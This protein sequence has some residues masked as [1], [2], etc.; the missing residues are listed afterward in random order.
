MT[1]LLLTG[2]LSLF[3][4]H[5]C[6]ATTAE[7]PL[8]RAWFKPTL[9][10]DHAAVCA[11]LLQASQAAFTRPDPVLEA[12][13]PRGLSEVQPREF[14]Q[15]Q[16]DGTQ[17]HFGIYTHPGCGG[18][19]EQ[20]Q[21]AA[22]LQPL[23]YHPAVT[24]DQLARSPERSSSM[25]RL[26]VDTQ[27]RVLAL[28]DD[29]E[30]SAAARN[31]FLHR[32]DEG[33]NWTRVCRIALAPQ[34]EGS[35]E[36]PRLK[37]VRL[38]MNQ[39][40]GAMGGLARGYGNC[41]SLD[42]GT[43]RAHRLPDN[44]N[45]MLHRPWALY[46]GE[47]HY[48]DPQQDFQADNHA[49]DKW[50]LTG[51]SE[52]QAAH[53][54]RQA[55]GQVQPVLAHFYSQAF[56]WSQAQSE[57]V[58]QAAL[59]AAVGN[60]L[61]FPSYGY[62]PFPD[63]ERALRQAILQSRPIKEI[64]QIDGTLSNISIAIEHPQ[65]L[66]FLLEQGSDPETRNPFGKTPLMYAAQYNQL[67]SA[68]LLLEAGADVNAMTIWP[69]DT[70]AYTL[71]TSKM[72]ALH[73][74]VRYASPELIELLLRHG[75]ATF[76][77]SVSKAYQEP[78]TGIALDWLKRHTA[79]TAREPN[80]HIAQTRIEELEQK[81]HAPS[82]EQLQ[83]HAS[84]LNLQAEKHYAEGQLT[85]AYRALLLAREASP[86]DARVLGNLSLIAFKLGN[87]GPALEAGQQV[88][89]SS[90]D[91]KQLANA[92]F[93]QGLVCEATG[94]HSYN[95]HSYCGSGSIYAYYHAASLDN[96]PAR[97]N[98]LLEQLHSPQQLR[99]QLTFAEEEVDILVKQDYRPAAKGPSIRQTLYV[100]YP[101]AI[102]LTPGDV[103]WQS[104]ERRVQPREADTLDLDQ[105]R[106]S[107][108]E[109]PE[110]LAGAPLQIGR[111]TCQPQQQ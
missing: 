79:S 70:C 74:A 93:N 64:R 75:A 8:D 27:Q 88:I 17:Q 25:P 59:E 111:D 31:L 90:Q 23:A 22:S 66:Q 107:V 10:E 43:R 14:S 44:L 4:A 41:G 97:Q 62:E 6:L 21:I 105:W 33:L 18:G 20:Y 63:E 104:K 91:A 9:Q 45:L 38:A 100:L 92:W 86:Q 67:E 35:S 69:E 11:E 87:Y 73:Y 2:L 85:A 3:A 72:T 65:A 95:A 51:L 1:R 101:S 30:P 46:A 82:A 16:A 24:D 42:V 32:L 109:S 7:I 61:A 29:S 15:Q 40:T 28:S 37:S 60:A 108:L 94:W 53:A 55:L 56:D 57:R 78:R 47:R 19:C 58:A 13:K 36:T 103:S 102:R 76:I 99:C 106:L 81:L 34:I 89:D 49:L 98:K 52:Y 50:A 77:S 80:V 96:T 39:L 68:R 83:H 84:Q 5:P 54:Y 71:E 12:L 110:T 48:Y 26:F